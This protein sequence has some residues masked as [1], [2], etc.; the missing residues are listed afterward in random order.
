MYKLLKYIKGNAIIYKILA[1]LMMFIEVIM[2]LNQPKLI[3]DIIDIGVVN[4]D[5][6]YVLNV[7]FKM[8]VVAIIRIL[9]GMLCG[10]FAILAS[11][12]MG[13]DMRRR[14]LDKIS[15]PGAKYLLYIKALILYNILV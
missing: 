2:D 13:K 12:T 9:G 11:M 1:P 8:I 5:I 6:H 3:E 4:G 14:N 15:I 10:V 7:G